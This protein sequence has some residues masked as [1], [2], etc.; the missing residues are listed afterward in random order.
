MARPNPE[1]KEGEQE[2]G[3][4]RR[5]QHDERIFPERAKPPRPTAE[6]LVPE[7]HAVVRLG[8][9][10]QGDLLIRYRLGDEDRDAGELH[11]CP[12]TGASDPGARLVDRQS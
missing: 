1:Y 5:A 12:A 7:M 11:P 10:G 9:G 8:D 6:R 3:W 4:D 2:E